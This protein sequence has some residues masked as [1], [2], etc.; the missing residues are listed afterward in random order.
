[1]SNTGR[2]KNVIR[3]TGFG[4]LYRL[5][6]TVIPF[7]MRTVLIYCLGIEY[8][9]L[10]SLFTS[11][12][13][14][15]NFAE[16]GI[17]SAMNFAMYQPIAQNDRKKICALLRAY[18]IYYLYIGFVILLIGVA[19]V[20]FLPYLVNKDLPADVNLYV[21]Y[22]IFLIPNV[23]SYWMFSYRCSLFEAHQRNDIISKINLVLDSIRFAI[24]FVV[25]LVYRNY[26]AYIIVQLTFQIVF[27][28]VVYYFVKKTYP[29]YK[30][31]GILPQEDRDVIKQRVKDIVTAKLGGMILNSSDTMIISAFLGLSVLAV[32]QNYYF[33]ISAVISFIAMALSG[34]MASIGNSIVTESREKVFSDFKNVS[35]MLSW[36]VAI[37]TCCFLSLFQPFMELWMGKELMLPFSIV[38]LFCVYFFLYEFNQL[39]NIYK[40][41]A[42]LWHEDKLRPLITSLS[43]LGINLLLVQHIGLHGVILSTVLS[44]LFIGMPW[45]LRNVFTYLFKTSMKDF[46]KRFLLYACI[47]FVSCIIVYRIS[48]MIQVGLVLTLFVRLMIA[49]L[50]PSVIYLILFFKKPEFRKLLELANRILRVRK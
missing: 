10:N 26:Y 1:M 33:L 8:V 31:S 47:T 32:Y 12:L 4:V 9:G 35:F 41:A 30:P 15:L 3:N 17:S 39:F 11:V 48:N 40:D 36:I 43:N 37:C 5:M 45:L 24:Q 29:D 6:Q 49:V 13:S 38:I 27:Q 34:A 46:L 28:F 16:L 22:A 44:M 2:V 18:R 42:G 20:P 21:L 50:V 25:L 7:F 23:L 19:V 14:V